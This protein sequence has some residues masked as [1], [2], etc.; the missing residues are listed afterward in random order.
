M[1]SNVALQNLPL[2]AWDGAAAV[3]R[4]IRR[5]VR[6]AWAFEVTAAIAADAVFNV[7]S[8]PPSAGD[9]C[10]P[11]AWVPVPEVSICDDPAVPGPQAAF[12]IPAGTPIGSVCT[13]T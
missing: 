6:F 3:P 7:Q 2:L 12:T 10:V 1:N 11:G 8:A 4:D 5:F 13:G 9:N